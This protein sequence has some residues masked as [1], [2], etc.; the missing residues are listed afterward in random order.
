M[1]YFSDN[2]YPC[3]LAVNPGL[4]KILMTDAEI[5]GIVRRKNCDILLDLNVVKK[6][7][8]NLG[9]SKLK[10]VKKPK[11]SPL[12]VEKDRLSRFKFLS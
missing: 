6:G 4:L 10:C 3:K 5:E 8:T 11:I 2:D 7:K 12:D 9:L 1:C